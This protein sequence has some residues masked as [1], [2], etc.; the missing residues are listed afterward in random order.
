MKKLAI[1]I[2]LLF[3]AAVLANESETETLTLPTL[4]F[5]GSPV[6]GGEFKIHFKPSKDAYKRQYQRALEHR[7][8]FPD[9]NATKTITA[10]SSLLGVTKVR[11]V[12]L[13]P[14]QEAARVKLPDTR[15]SAP[16]VPEATPPTPI[17]PR[18]K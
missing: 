14:S 9:A 11:V 15:R 3:S 18:R 8:T 7:Q 2:P 1:L 17:Q 13:T 6:I 4:K 5:Y 16:G 12:T 10:R